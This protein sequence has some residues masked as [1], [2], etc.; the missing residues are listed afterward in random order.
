[1]SFYYVEVASLWG[2][3][4]VGTFA[5]IYSVIF[6]RDKVSRRSAVFNL[7]SF[8]ITSLAL[9]F[10][11]DRISP[12][13]AFSFQL[14]HKWILPQGASIFVYLFFADFLFYLYHRLTHTIPI[15]WVGH[16]SHHSGD[17]LHL[18]LV[19]RD[20][21]V[22]HI[23]VLPMG[24]LGIPLGVTPYGL[25]ICMRFVIFYQAF[26]HFKTKRDWPILNYF[27]VT[28]YNHVIHHST[29]FDGAGHNFGGILCIW[30]RLCGTY[31]AGDEY[32]NAIGIRDLK[33]PD[34]L[35][36]INAVPTLELLKKCWTARSAGPLFFFSDASPELSL[37]TTP[38]RGQRTSN[39]VTA[40]LY[41]V[42]LLLALDI[43][44]RA[45]QFYG[46]WT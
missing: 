12:T 24:L 9:Q 29:R 36:N 30:D 1:M 7:V 21:I 43:V 18:S 46:I 5:T 25:Y 4:I 37:S 6:S 44:R 26:L 14:Q 2:T 17:K 41:A 45:L 19:I 8:L 23:F 42:A 11:I 35:W 10:V 39:W 33:N 22:S 28:Q 16:Y 31:R 32:L 13:Y 27:L 40:P 3:A 34:S 38:A 15:L 20:N